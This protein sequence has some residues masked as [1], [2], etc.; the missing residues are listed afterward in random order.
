[1][2]YPK[3]QIYLS[4]IVPQIQENILNNLFGSEY[5]NA[6]TLLQ[7]TSQIKSADS[8]DYEFEFRFVDENGHT[9]KQNWINFENDFYQSLLLQSYDDDIIYNYEPLIPLNNIHFRSYRKSGLY[10]R[11]IM[12]SMVVSRSESKNTLLPLNLRLSK[13]TLMSP[14][15]HLEK[16]I[17]IHAIHC[18][19][20]SLRSAV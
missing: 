14:V 9:S 15:K 12:I 10:E 8:Q 7:T 18:T 4:K 2:S 20:R 6:K 19:S 1:M 16:F 13:E 5:V 17:N 3:D 11:K